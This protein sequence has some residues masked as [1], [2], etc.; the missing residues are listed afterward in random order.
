MVPEEETSIVEELIV[1]FV[2]DTDTKHNDQVDL[3]LALKAL[4][5]RVD[6]FNCYGIKLF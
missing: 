2:F 6:D 4:P 5:V 1:K 3:S